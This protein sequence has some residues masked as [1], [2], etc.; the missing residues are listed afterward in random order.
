[1]KMKKDDESLLLSPKD[2]GSNEATLDARISVA[3]SNT[4]LDL[5]ELSTD[6]SVDNLALVSESLFGLMCV[7]ATIHIL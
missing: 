3:C 6:F 7:E 1:M 5:G 4:C 2:P